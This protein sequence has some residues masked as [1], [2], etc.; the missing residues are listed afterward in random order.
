M[1]HL[2]IG[3]VWLLYC[4]SLP[5]SAAPHFDISKGYRLS[6]TANQ[7]ILSQEELLNLDLAEL[8]E[9]EVIVAS[10]STELV[11]DAPSS[12]TVFTHD[13]I[14][15]MGVTTLGELLD[16]VPGFQSF[17]LALNGDSQGFQVRGNPKLPVFTRDVLLMVDGQRLNGSHSGGGI[18]YNAYINLAN[19]KQVEVIRGPGSALY[20][21][22]AFLGVIN[23]IT[24]EDQNAV[25]I[26]GGSYNAKEILLHLSRKYA[27]W[28]ADF[29][30]RA[31]TDEGDY[32]TNLTDR[33]GQ[34]GN[35]RDARQAADVN[36]KLKKDN[37]S[38]HLRHIH[39]RTEDF[40]D[41][42]YIGDNGINESENEQSSLAFNY[43]YPA[44]EV[45]NLNLSG[46]YTR[47]RLYFLSDTGEGRHH[48]SD[49]FGLYLENDALDISLDSDWQIS[50]QS[51]WQSGITFKNTGNTDSALIGSLD[52]QL[53]YRRGAESF[54]ENRDR[55]ILG[56]Y[57]QYQHLLQPELNMVLGLRYDHYSDFGNTLNPRGALIY[58]LPWQDRLKLMYGQAFRA[59]NLADLTLNVANS[60]G[61]PNLQPEKVETAEFSYIY[62]NDY[63]QSVM[64]LFNNHISDVITI[65]PDDTGQFFARNEGVLDRSG[66]EL[67][68]QL[69]PF[70]NWLVRA[71]YTRIFEGAERHAPREFG[72]L[73]FNYQWQ[74]W[75]VNLNGTYHSELLSLSNPRSTWMANTS[76]R[77]QL[78]PNVILQG[79]IKNLRDKHYYDPSEFT[80]LENGQLRS[81]EPGIPLRGRHFWLGLEINF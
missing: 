54:T 26:R 60:K 59:P 13:E 70:S 6:Q 36:L 3:F 22:N 4:L 42:E 16:F 35:A 46:S 66:L 41:S 10:K 48:A 40:L 17:R 53:I 61:N 27:G 76:I 56:L 14:Q 58:T 32:Y 24:L 28:K 65:E 67:E 39:R 62:I 50:P 23:I 72:S 8:L 20:G 68:L 19:V 75:N 2:L 55:D 37:F 81:F 49:L 9:V 43:L 63:G 12:V 73:I 74:R 57:G 33:T 52:R 30:A 80:A 21:S 1:Q 18:L 79:T 25:S 45:F 64:T 71:S 78:R 11:A 7:A 29:F 44:S 31:Y 77:Y 51:S 38:F 34:N 47:S 5:L 69:E 15:S